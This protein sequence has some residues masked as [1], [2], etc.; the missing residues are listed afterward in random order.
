MLSKAINQGG[1][2][3]NKFGDIIYLFKI[4]LITN[5]VLSI[6][7]CFVVNLVT[8]YIIDFDGFSD[9]KSLIP[10][11]FSGLNIAIIYAI[12]GLYLESS[13]SSIL[14][15]TLIC[16]AGTMAAVMISGASRRRLQK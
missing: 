16:F 1:G 6:L 8:D 12:L 3:A 7:S 14:M 9:K 15:S 13:V 2:L 10:W 5:V 4:P 11:L